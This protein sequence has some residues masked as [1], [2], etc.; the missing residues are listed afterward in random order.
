[1][2][3]TLQTFSITEIADLMED[4]AISD[5]ATAYKEIHTTS[6]RRSI[7]ARGANQV[8]GIPAPAISE[9]EEQLPRK[10]RR[11]LVQLRSCFYSSLNDYK[12]RVGQSDTQICPC[13][14]QEEHTV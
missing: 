13:C 2:K 8:I 1:M 14:R 4:G 11:T 9:E 5:A 6:V 10:T 7:E 12:H 3:K